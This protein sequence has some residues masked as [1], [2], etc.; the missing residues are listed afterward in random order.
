[1]RP[2]GIQASPNP[3]TSRRGAQSFFSDG[4]EPP[5]HG[6]S[7]NAGFSL[8]EV[9]VATAVLSVALVSLAQLFAIAT[10]A[11]TSS[12]STTL[13][14]VLAE[15]KMEH[16]RSLTWG[17]DTIGL[18]F[19]DFSTDVSVVPETPTGGT[20]LSPSPA[21]TLSQNTAGF[22]DYLDPFGRWVGTGTL[23]PPG[24]AYIRR[25]SVEPLPT[26]PNNTLILQVLVTRNRNR[27]SADDG[28][29]SR[30]PDEARLVS[31]K[32]RKSI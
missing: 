24:T 17:F 32:T 4:A 9:L 21:G 30:L 18:P 13:A 5:P 12:R 15:Q 22:V 26:N 31:I 8:A 19:S 16:L 7:N 28:P 11:N 23:P 10:R 1:M 29:V 14:A 25:W 6:K 27:G 2:T 20:G 3:T